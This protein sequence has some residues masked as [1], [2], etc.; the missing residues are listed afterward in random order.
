MPGTGVS[1]TGVGL[2]VRVGVRVAAGVFVS[3]GVGAPGA[4]EGLEI[5]M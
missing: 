5:S 4:L 2:G 3:V 1:S